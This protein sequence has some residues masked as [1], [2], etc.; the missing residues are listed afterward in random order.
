MLLSALAA[1]WVTVA[2]MYWGQP[3]LPRLRPQMEAQL[4]RL[5]EQPV[6]IGRLQV[7]W[8]IGPAIRVHDL[9][10]GDRAQ[11]QILL[12]HLDIELHPLPLLWGDLRVRRLVLERPYLNAERLADGRIKIGGKVLGG[13]GDNLSLTLDQADIDLRGGTMD[14]RDA[15]HPHVGSLRLQR[16][17]LKARSAY[18][19]HIEASV[20]LPAALGSELRVKMAV[21]RLFSDPINSHGEG[22][23]TVRN[24]HTDLLAGYFAEV[25]P[26][27]VGGTVNGV[28]DVGWHQAHIHRL[29]GP[30][31]VRQA[32]FNWPDYYQ[33]P[34][35]ARRLDATLDW[36]NL[37][38]QGSLQLRDVRLQQADTAWPT[39]NVA[40]KSSMD[41]GPSRIHLQ[42][43]RMEVGPTIKLLPPKL[44][45]TTWR[46]R[47]AE[48]APQGKIRNFELRWHEAAPRSPE[49]FAVGAD[50]SEMRSEPSAALPGFD[51]VGGTFRLVDWQGV[52]ELHG[53]RVSL[54]W[55]KLF[56]DRIPIKTLHSQITWQRQAHQLSVNIAQ[57]SVQTD[58][59]LRGR[60]RIVLRPGQRPWVDV[61][62]NARGVPVAAV[63]QYYP[64][65]IMSKDL[66]HWLDHA[67]LGGRVDSATL[68]LRG[69][70]AK[71]PFVNPRDG[72]FRVVSQLN[73]VGLRYHPDWPSL[74][75]V[76]GQMLFDRQRFSLR[77]SSGSTFD[78]PLQGVV[79]DIPDLIH[80]RPILAVQGH[81]D[82]PF[83]HLWHFLR[84]SPLL[85]GSGL[86]RAD[87]R[88][89][90]QSPLD[91]QLSIP[92]A[93]VH[94]TTVAGTLDMQQVDLDWDSL[95]LS[96]LS[97][98][99]HFTEHNIQ[100]SALQAQ[101]L[102]GPARIQVDAAPLGSQAQIHVRADGQVTPAGL[103][104]QFGHAWIA[105]LQGDIPY[106][107]DFN[108]QAHDLRGSYQWRSPLQGV[109][110][111]FP[112]PLAKA[113]DSAMQLEAS[114]DFEVG[115]RIQIAAHVD[116]RHALRL[117]FDHAPSGWQLGLGAWRMGTAMPP[118]LPKQG[119]RVDG[120]GDFLDLESW[121]DWIGQQGES[122]SA[123]QGAAAWPQVQ[124]DTDWCKLHYLRRDWNDLRIRGDIIGAERRIALQLDSPQLQG[125]VDFAHAPGQDPQL[126]LRLARLY[127]PDNLPDAKQTAVPTAPTAASP[128]AL[129][130]E[131]QDIRWRDLH[132]DQLNFQGQYQPTLWRIQPLYL[133]Q[134]D[135]EFNG[136]LL[137]S[138]ADNNRSTIK[139]ELKA[140]HLANT[141]K[142]FALNSGLDEGKAQITVVLDWPGQPSDFDPA[143]LSGTLN[144]NIEDGRFTAVSPV[145]K[146]LSLINV[147]QVL[148]DVVTLD[149]RDFTGDGLFFQQMRGDFGLEQGIARTQNLQLNSGA[150]RV[151]TEG[152]INLKERNMDLDLKVQ[153]LQTLDLL[154]ARFPLIGKALFGADGAVLNLRY[155]ASGTWQAPK[156]E[157]K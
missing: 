129:D 133:R 9:R 43:D 63:P 10:V 84:S 156:I 3:E 36:R 111:Q 1:A 25:L 11:P 122:A 140:A 112:A 33:T 29:Y 142:T 88:S 128:V 143:Q 58:F 54:H 75:Q 45:P 64:F 141:L 136:Q 85:K 66:L 53:E 100:A 70:L 131:I 153:P 101:W 119:L 121:L 126:K 87:I 5:L 127:L 115:R 78:L 17:N 32:S 105:Q 49:H 62:A 117:Q 132:L 73:R 42:I 74:E 24:L 67:F 61:Q 15:R 12:P 108:M 28:I 38:Q 109:A 47:L 146:L 110:S 23:L 83:G 116:D 134:E 114:G 120:E 34:L 48:A 99:L 13:R 41:G 81:V 91:L 59:P 52:L 80:H 57:F 154:I 4:S 113:A 72:E 55:P 147:L 150:M 89:S 44:L 7:Y 103:Q 139:G 8:R 92:L 56:R 65:R 51:H 20:H 155:H 123:R 138:Q 135:A 102:G 68:R 152:S 35:Q 30:V 69:P 77:A 93:H 125:Q 124:I 14:W 2:V 94:E 148:R 137:W 79:A 50:F 71:F 39:F 82:A 19:Q 37:G 97:G 76:S 90:G 60:A 22:R 107:F 118:D 21:R 98:P 27:T 40:L 6:H 106:Q 86:A 16:F 157:S 104:A 95:K 149:F 46:D 145:T 144:L 18:R 31:Q 96:K 26:F 151:L 130:A